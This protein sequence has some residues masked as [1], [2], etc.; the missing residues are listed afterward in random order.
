GF[1]APVDRRTLQPGRLQQRGDQLAEAVQVLASRHGTAVAAVLV[2]L[3]AALLL[4]LRAAL[5]PEIGD[6]LPQALVEVRQQVG[7]GRAGLTG[8]S[9]GWRWK[10]TPRFSW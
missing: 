9:G 7:H 2:T 4:R 10:I 3:V 1:L 6:G 5:L 8:E